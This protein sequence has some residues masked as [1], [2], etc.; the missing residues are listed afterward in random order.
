MKYKYWLL[1]CCVIIFCTTG[2]GRIENEQREETDKK[3]YTE[4]E[5]ADADYYETDEEDTTYE[6][7]T[8]EPL[9]IA[10]SD[11]Y[12]EENY[13]LG[14][15]SDNQNYA[16][17]K[18]AA[19]SDKGFYALNEETNCIDFVDASNGEQVVLCSDVT[20]NHSTPECNAWYPGFYGVYFNDGYV[21]VMSENM[22]ADYVCLYR[23]NADG[24]NKVTVAK[25]YEHEEGDLP[26]SPQFI[27]HRGYGYLIINW[28]ENST[29]IEREQ[30][31]YK[32][33]LVDGSMEEIFKFTGYSPNIC[34][35]NTD[36]D[37][38][39]FGTSQNKNGNPYEYLY[40]E[41]CYNI[42]DNSI[43]ERYTP[44]K[45]LI[46]R[47]SNGKLYSL[48]KENE[49]LEN[50][51]MI[52]KKFCIYISDTDGKHS[53]CIY[54]VSAEEIKKKIEISEINVDDNYIY[55]H[56]LING[57]YNYFTIIDHEGKEVLNLDCSKYGY[58]RWSDGK[59]LLLIDI[60]TSEYSVYDIK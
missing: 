57:L 53:K 22:T 55:L 11:E 37:R 31:L 3:N 27:I 26:C 30:S 12:S 48:E 34:L 15:F 59:R 4:G 9:V 39:F 44:K 38:L 32:V 8:P 1:L 43:T 60:E 50:G 29:S 21:Y 45:G 56:R 25:L 33:S 54:K 7:V 18:R 49:Y 52:N 58:C 14:K 16:V 51:M 35:E 19:Y 28:M 23:M 24:S 47:C 6:M 42:D 17:L 10:H 40:K 41:Y 36:K 20:C 46:I 13:K 5:T 2:C